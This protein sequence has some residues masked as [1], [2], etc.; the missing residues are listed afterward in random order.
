MPF[1]AAGIAFTAD[2]GVALGK[3]PTAIRPRQ[4]G[5]PL[6]IIEATDLDQWSDRRDAQAKLPELINRLIR[7]EVGAA[8][9]P[10]FPSG[11][12][13]QFQGW[14]GVCDIEKGM[15][16]VP[17]GRSVW[18]LS[19][20]SKSPAKK[21]GQ[22][23]KKRTIATSADEQGST[24][25]VLVTTRRQ[26]S[27]ERNAKEWQK[28]SH[29]RDVRILDADD[30]VQWIEMHPR[31]ANWL[32]AQI[33]KRSE[34]TLQLED[35]WEEWAH[36]TLPTMSTARVLAG[37]DEE[38]AKIHRWLQDPP[39]VL[40]LQAE[41]IDE[42]V[43]FLYAAIDQY[44]PAYRAPDLARTIVATSAATARILGDGPSPL[45]LVLMA[46]EP[47]L[48]ER[49]AARGHH[50]YVA[51]GAEAGPIADL[52]PLPH[53]PKIEIEW[54]LNVPLPRSLNDVPHLRVLGRPIKFGEGAGWIG[55]QVGRITG[56][57]GTAS[58]ANVTAGYRRRSVDNFC[59][60]M[61]APR[62]KITGAGSAY[63]VQALQGKRDASPF[64]PK[65]RGITL[66]R[67]A[68]FSSARFPAP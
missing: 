25:F 3:T 19:T 68:A 36:S 26:S 14:D 66:T 22:D 23:F 1:T 11:E 51:Y 10:T 35:V 5:Q 4:P 42:T 54:A 33:G 15:G 32:A 21:A 52:S 7:A 40:P 18:E 58:H 39:A 59:H 12:S 55:N 34:G 50:V 38:A 13:V 61:T 9:G 41:T 57:T 65:D 20:Q 46:T 67:S 43:A 47:G 44:P 17:S 60:R 56:T 27:K 28:E 48:A 8:A 24:S 2:G 31:V 6:R 45:V 62:A 49:L 29:W 53:P 16:Y 30:L 37:R 63:L 64:A